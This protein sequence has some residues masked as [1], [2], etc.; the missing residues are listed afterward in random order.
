MDP[1]AFWDAYSATK[2]QAEGLVLAANGTHLATPG[3]VYPAVEVVA[4]M[5]MAGLHGKGAA[6]PIPSAAVRR[7]TR[8]VTASVKGP[9]ADTCPSA[10]R[11]E[12]GVV[13]ATTSPP[14]PQLLLRTCAI[15]PAGIYG[16]GECRHLPRVVAMV[17]AGG[18]GAG[19][20][21]G[22]SRIVAIV[23]AGGREVTGG[24]SRYCSMSQASSRR[25]GQSTVRPVLVSS[26]SSPTWLPFPQRCRSPGSTSSLLP[27]APPPLIKVRTGMFRFVFDVPGSRTDW[28]H[29]ENL[30]QALVLAAEGLGAGREHAAAGQVRDDAKLGPRRGWRY[31]LSTDK[32]RLKRGLAAAAA[33]LITGFK[34]LSPYLWSVHP[35]CRLTLCPTGA[36]STTLSSSGPSSRAWGTIIPAS[37]CRTGG[38][39]SLSR[40][41]R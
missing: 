31:G 15:R 25:S 26:P 20:Q 27:P 11:S 6:P 37:A 14:A 7:V 12:E 38:S 41:H 29:V 23:R 22:H 36:L 4:S 3:A 1:S 35:I 8:S 18:G 2:A 17:R 5:A 24:W 13:S 39:S 9:S 33:E 21:G 19:L 10:L 16:P 28:L 30:V 32:A 40:G 34:S